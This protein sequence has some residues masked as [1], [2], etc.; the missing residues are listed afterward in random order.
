[1]PGKASMSRHQNRQNKKILPARMI[2]KQPVIKF[3]NNRLLYPSYFFLYCYLYNLIQEK[4]WR[5]I[6]YRPESTDPTI[7]RV[8]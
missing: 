7:L 3:F 2:I 5:I 6:L 1:M 4:V 8:S